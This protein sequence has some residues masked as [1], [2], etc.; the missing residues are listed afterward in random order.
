M[1]MKQ[2]GLGADSNIATS[3]DFL[4]DMMQ[5]QSPIQLTHQQHYLHQ[6]H[7]PH[8]NPHLSHSP[9]PFSLTPVIKE[10]VPTVSP[11][12]TSALCTSDSSSTVSVEDMMND[13]SP[14]ADDPML[15]VF[16]ISTNIHVEPMDDPIDLFV[17]SDLM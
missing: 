7:S 14:V 11:S 2:A 5:Q 17:P 13:I 16:D 15:A 12:S 10:E 4:H 8:V 6:Q 1:K 9:H 3:A